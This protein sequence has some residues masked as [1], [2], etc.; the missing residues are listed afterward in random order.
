VIDTA[1]PGR[2]DPGARTTTGTPRVS[3]SLSDW[4][5]MCLTHSPAPVAIVERG[6]YRLLYANPVF[7]RLHAMSATS[8]EL[9]L[10]QLLAP[11]AAGALIAVIDGGLASRELAHEGLIHTDSGEGDF[12]CSVWPLADTH[13]GEHAIVMLELRP[14]TDVERIRAFQVDVTQRLLLSALH[15]QIAAEAA[16][17]AVKV[18][19][20]AN[21]AQARFL[22]T[23]SHELRTPLNA[24]GGYTE[25]INM[26]LRGPVT[27]AQRHDLSRIQRA[28]EHLMGLINSVLNYSKLESGSVRFEMSAVDCAGTLRDVLEMLMPHFTRQHLV[29][30]DLS[31]TSPDGSPLLARADPEKLRQIL[32]NILTNAI[33]FT[34][35]GGTISTCCKARDDQILIHVSDT[36]RGIPQDQLSTIFDPFVQVGRQLSSNDQGVGLGLSISRDLARAMG[37][38]L[39]ATSTLGVG[40]TFTVT[41]QRASRD[42]PPSP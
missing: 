35:A 1:N 31:L 34:E 39:T 10:S 42:A 6:T 36:G 17:A 8:R 33:K 4:A 28:Q 25:L 3:Q 30:D 22:S 20:L 32:I 5:E 15:D 18:A 29:Y 26:G 40:S 7:R 2:G 16:E 12:H 38:E 14:E 21:A 13:G 27:A 19:D 24:I 9:P 11:A 37:G 23:M 41:L